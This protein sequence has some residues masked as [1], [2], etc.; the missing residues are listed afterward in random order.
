MAEAR[1]SLWEG[2]HPALRTSVPAAAVTSSPSTVGALSLALSRSISYRQSPAMGPGP[3]GSVPFGCSHRLWEQRRGM[4]QRL[5]GLFLPALFPF[6]L[7]REPP[8]TGTLSFPLLPSR[9]CPGLPR[10]VRNILSWDTGRQGSKGSGAGLKG[11]PRPRIQ[12]PS[13]SFLLTVTRGELQ[14]AMSF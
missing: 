9:C 8:A 14:R 11:I 3:C 4:I 13:L 1:C 6:F 10:T 12:W 2:V 5:S 7:S